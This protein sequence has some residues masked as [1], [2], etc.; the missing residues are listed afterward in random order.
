M[1]SD[2]EDVQNTEE[3]R[4]QV[5]GGGGTSMHSCHPLRVHLAGCVTVA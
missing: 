4:T 3:Q 2:A 1:P 5:G